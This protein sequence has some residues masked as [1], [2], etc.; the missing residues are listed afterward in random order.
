MS[1]KNSIIKQYI[2]ANCANTS[3]KWS[4][5]CLNCLNWNTI[6]EEFISKA[7][8]HARSQD[9]ISHG[10][11]LNTF[12]LDENI[13]EIKKIKINIE[14][15]NRVLG[16]GLVE[17]S[18]IL[19]GGEPGI[20]KSTITMQLCNTVATLGYISLYVSAEESINQIKLRAERLNIKTD[21]IKLASSGSVEDII[22]TLTSDSNIKLVII[23]SIQTMQTN[24]IES[25]PGSVSQVKATSN[26]LINYAKSNNII[27]FIVGHVTKDGSIGG[28]KLLEHMVDTVLYFENDSQNNLRIIR[29]IKNRF[30]S[31]NELG[32]FNMTKD[33]LV[34][35][36]N[37]SSFFLG[38]RINSTGS[39]IFAGI[40]GARPLIVEVQALLTP[41]NMPTPRRSVVG[42][43]INRLATILAVL[44][45]RAKI[46]L[47][48]YEVYLSIA[49]GIKINDPTIDLAVAASII[50]SVTKKTFPSDMIFFGEIGLSGEVRGANFVE[51][52]IKESQKL[53]FKSIVTHDTSKNSVIKNINHISELMNLL[54]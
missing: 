41:S 34:E 6:S 36:K 4:G 40:E 7:D 11:I 9:N 53:G 44:S 20:G 29:S 24:T 17:G 54:K 26:M 39:S 52:R 5:Q 45:V 37:P 15:L 49:G 14:E 18:A 12:R 22:A 23:D 48:S 30:G 32:I 28:P 13:E 51:S 33:G 42:W 25:T 46:S 50:S 10:K 27:L 19:I 16:G 47:F 35:V 8:L 21:K 3:N 31:V 38:N 2:C 1:K 43:D